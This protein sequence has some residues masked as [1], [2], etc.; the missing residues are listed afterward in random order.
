MNDGTKLWMRD[1]DT[2]EVIRHWVRTE[3]RE[4]IEATVRVLA[5]IATRGTRPSLVTLR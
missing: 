3:S 2:I 1:P 4:R 5:D